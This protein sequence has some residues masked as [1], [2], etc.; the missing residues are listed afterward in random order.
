MGNRPCT[1][2]RR[3]APER[4]GSGGAPAAG[5][6]RSGNECSAAGRPADTIRRFAGRCANQSVPASPGPSVVTGGQQRWR[7]RRN[8]SAGSPGSA[9]SAT[10]PG[11]SRTR[12][13]RAG[14]PG[15]PWPA[16]SSP[17][18]AWA[19]SSCSAAGQR[20]T[21]RPPP[22]PAGEHAVG[23][24]VTVRR[25]PRRRAGAYL[26]LQRER[27]G[28]AQG[29]AAAQA[30][31]FPGPLPGH[32]PHQPRQYRDQS[33]EQQGHLHG[34]LVRLAGHRRSTSTRPPAT[35]SPRAASSCCNAATPRVPAAAALATSSVTRTWLA[36]STRRARWPW[37]T[38][39][40]TPMAA[41]F[42]WCTR[43]HLGCSLI[44]PR[45]EPSS[46]GLKSSRMWPRR[47]ATTPTVPGEAGTRR[48][49]SSSRA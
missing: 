6:A 2:G 39:G 48:R 20:T 15:S 21:P 28:R 18:L 38:R 49:K 11:G 5:K 19:A 7:G 1:A 30:P 47:A 24:P 37:P 25:G 16:C 41:S 35:G 44:T 33:A 43:T 17:A 40:R 46:A 45:S 14:S 4:R 29:R 31:R 34:E 42:S 32:H 27:H 9:T 22:Q 23:Q 10:S 26:R 8:A 12:I 3:P 13:G 36:R